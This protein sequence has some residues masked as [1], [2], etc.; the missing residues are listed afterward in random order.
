MS[1]FVFAFL[2]GVLPLAAQ[3]S[4]LQGLITDA[5]TAAIPDAI[6]TATNQDTSATRRTLSTATGTFNFP[7]VAPGVYK[8]T[9]EKPG[10]GAYSSE[11]R[12]QIDTPA[13]LNIQLELGQVN[14]TVSVEA[15]ASSVNTQNASVGNPFTENQIKGLPLQTRNVV[16]LLKLQPG[17]APTGEVIG[18]RA[19]Q[20]NVTLD[21]ID[22][23]DNQ[24]ASGF[25]AVLPVPLDSVQEFRTTVAGLGADQGR[26]SGGQVSLVTKG[27]SNDFHGSLY[28]YNRN[29]YFSADSWFNNRAGVARTPLIRNQY[30]AALGGRL[31]RN[32]AFFF[33]N[34]ED[35]KDRSG[36]ATT[37]IVPSETFKQG[38]VQVA[39]SNG[40]TAQLN[41][42]DIVAVDPTHAGAN[43]FMQSLFKQYPAGNDP[44]S[45]AD[46]GLNFSILRFNAPQNLNN[47][48]YVGRL[49]FNLD[50][51]GK[52]TLMLRGTLAANS[53]DSS[54]TAGIAQF[55][56]QA[57]PAQSLDNS[58]GLAARYT[59]VI[60]PRVINVLSYGLTRLG[61]TSTGSSTVVPS[62]YFATLQA[63]PRASQRIAP[64]TNLV[65]DLTWV[66]GRHTVQAGANFRIVQNDR[67]AYN[68]LPNYSFSRNTLLGLGGDVT[69]NVL[70]LM[71]SRYGSAIK[72]SSATNVTN[73]LG[74]LYGLINQYGATYN[75]GA[76]GKAVPF[77]DGVVRSFGTQEYEFF[78]QD[79]FKWRRNFTVTYGLRYSVDTVPYERNGVEGI[80]VQPLSQFFAD[81]VGGQAAGVPSAA[82]S[83]AMITYNL[84]GPVNHGPSWFPRDNNNFA[85]RLALAY[86]PDGDGLLTRL[87]G[88]GS[89][90]R[91][92]AGIVY[93]HYGTNMVTSFASSGSPGLST[94][95]SQPL[96]TDFTTSF[97]YN[98]SAL[99]ALPVA[100]ASGF[101]Y[102][103]GVVI[104][105]FTAF[106]G[107]ASN[108]VAPYQ[109]L[110]NASYS[111]PLPK[112]MSLEVGYIGRLSHKGLMQQDYAQPLTLFKDV[113]S[114]QTWSQA[115]TMLKRLYDSGITPA[116]VQANPSLIPQI[117]FFEDMFPGAKNYKFTGSASA[118]Y[119]YSVYGTY[120]GSD[121]DALNDMDR[122]RQSNG[123]CISVYGCN[124]FF[125]KQA[126]GL[127]TWT[128]SGKSG[129][130]G[131]QLIWRRPV[132][133]GWGFDFNYTLSHSI[134]N[135]SGSET[136]G[137]GVQDAFN[138]DGYRGP[139]NFDIRHQVTA[140]TVV[141]LPFGK[142]KALLRGIP[143]WAN[144]IVGGWQVSLL[145]T[146][147]TGTPLNIA[148]SGLYPT[149][150][151]NSALGIL[152]PGATMPANHLASDE[153]GIPSIFSSTSAVQSFEGQDPGT[154]GTRGIVRVPGSVNFDMSVSKSFR[155]PWEGHR[156]SIRGEAFNAFNHVNF[157]TP[158]VSLATPSTFGELTK[159]ADPRVMQ[160]ALRYEF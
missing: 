40:T 23:N 111:R 147:R 109:Y 35:R 126:A 160:F 10:F 97:R 51:A 71:Q 123:S 19:D 57:S 155:L 30:G 25:N 56:G 44:K 29:T 13:V 3:T 159:T 39:L 135:V 80:P 49:D 107:V 4:S 47:R 34:W 142:N 105:G 95:L 144:A 140:N 132:T 138:P 156:V 16:D 158:N 41:A 82:L 27:G 143:G 78:L 43:P 157:T 100:T 8:V 26:S 151:L 117:G 90:L 154:D 102:T 108:L 121:L 72:L 53:Q 37:R 58:R 69:A 85:P 42:A 5:Q 54:Q 36:T 1:R 133:N 93:D 6:V 118:N 146:M 50:S 14:Q 32:R 122:L 65:D 81:R 55:P 52:H 77:G 130:N 125:A 21:G 114:G 115:S 113:K 129:F 88:K 7:Q 28:E 148:N 131:L 17:V 141:E 60:S 66:K 137:A 152:R 119:Y 84:G 153:K 134:D 9:V 24:G 70:S 18:A 67:T 46:L 38:I 124:T 2:L 104:G 98:G 116:Q 76:D 110:L 15:T 74:A 48:A 112:K 75:F 11:V 89:A 145:A 73:A 139:S 79:S 92:G 61:N 136:D 150:Y 103:P 12:L 83:T 94:T 45:S 127:T 99:P 63:T 59:A 106:S 86:A 101:P 64:T 87:L 128:N 91:A 22:V 31:I 149:N 33:F 68:N 120:A 20:N 96:N 62:F